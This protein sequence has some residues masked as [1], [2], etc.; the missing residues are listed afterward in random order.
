MEEIFKQN[1]LKLRTEDSARTFGDALFCATY[2]RPQGTRP[3]LAESKAPI[4]HEF[5]EKKQVIE[6]LERFVQEKLDGRPGPLPVA[7]GEI[8]Q[9]P[10]PSWEGVRLVKDMEALRAGLTLPKELLD[11]SLNDKRAGSV[12]AIFVT[13]HFRSWTEVQPEL[14]EGPV[15]E[16]L[17]GFVLKTAE[18]FERMIRAMKLAP[19]EVALYPVEFEE[20]DVSLEVMSLAAYLRPEVLITL[21]AKAS[22][23]ILKSNDRLTLIHG[24][25][26]P[27]TVEGVGTFQVV[28]LFHPSIIET[29]Q[30]MKKTAWTDMQKIMKHLKKL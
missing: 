25:F 26:F 29:N 13:E 12:K 10:L 24:Q 22:Q 19:E 30:N 18:F 21:G 2:W 6:S 23:R 17:P 8:V 11:L 4:N 9:K 1:L 28:P 20:R 5:S 7:G 14:K 27:R 16:L 3:A 15:S